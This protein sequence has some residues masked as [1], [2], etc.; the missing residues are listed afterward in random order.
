MLTIKIKFLLKTLITALVFSLILFLS[1]GKI[2]YFQGWI[3]LAG[4]LI[5]GFMNYWTIRNDP[6]LMNERSNVADNAKSW[7]KKILGISAL[8]YVLNVILAGLDSGRFQCSAQFHWSLYAGGVL[9]LLMG[10]VIFLAARKQNRYF[11]SVVRI[12]KD[13][14]HK[15]CDSGLYRIV[16]HPGYL[17]MIISLASIPLITGSVWSSLSTGLAILLLVIRTQLEDKTLLNEL[18]GY[19]SYSQ[20]TRFKLIPGVW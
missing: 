12:Q 4:N 11:S 6:E 18:E 20:K 13:R 8:V 9:F 16:R 1:A 5:T 3:F 2:D 15:V 7:D 19:I 10:Q 17:G 14:E